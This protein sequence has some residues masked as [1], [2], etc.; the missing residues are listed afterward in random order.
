MACFN[1][2]YM[3]GL[4]NTQLL[5]YSNATSIFLRVQAFNQNIRTRRIAGNK[6]LSYYSFANN[7]EAALYRQ[8]Q[9]LLFQNDPIGAA[10]GTYNDVLEI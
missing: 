3:T 7:T 5:G 8:G 1:V 6:T 9:F 4:S 2:G 10:A